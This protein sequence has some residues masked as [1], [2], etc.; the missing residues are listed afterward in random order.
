MLTSTTQSC[1]LLEELC[2]LLYLSW[3]VTM[4][5]Q[6][7]ITA[8]S[9]QIL[10]LRLKLNLITTL[11]YYLIDRNL[12]Y[13]TLCSQSKR[14]LDRFPKRKECNWM[15]CNAK[16]MLLS[17]LRA[18]P[19]RRNCHS[20]FLFI[21]VKNINNFENYCAGHSKP[22]LGSRAGHLFCEQWT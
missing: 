15:Q 9:N 22:F 19:M 5:G 11:Q 12:Y 1:H 16:R 17:P 18:T 7:P 14:N 20:F 6:H 8:I 2:P 10:K 4:D 3:V 21:H 13:R